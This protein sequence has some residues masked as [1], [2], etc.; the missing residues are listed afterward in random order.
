MPK[1]AISLRCPTKIEQF[2]DAGFACSCKV[3]VLYLVYFKTKDIYIYICIQII[4]VY[5]GVRYR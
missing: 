4:C 1:E 3:L 5:S 2:E